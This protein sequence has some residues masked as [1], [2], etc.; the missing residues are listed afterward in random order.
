MTAKMSDSSIY[1]KWAKQNC[2]PLPSYSNSEKSANESDD[3]DDTVDS[4][5]ST[6]VKT[7]E[8]QNLGPFTRVKQIPSDLMKVS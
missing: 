4:A 3:D 8:T 2:A 7:D 1:W 5:V 6:W